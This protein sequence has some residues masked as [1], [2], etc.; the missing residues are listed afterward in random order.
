MLK[1]YCVEL[2]EMTLDGIRLT[3]GDGEREATITLCGHGARDIAY[4]L[5]QVADRRRCDGYRHGDEA[6]VVLAVEL[7]A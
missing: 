4:K 7:P 1:G 6:S 5:V 3:I 2:D